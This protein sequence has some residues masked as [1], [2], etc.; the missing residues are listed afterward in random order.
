[1]SKLIAFAATYWIILLACY[2]KY[3]LKAAAL[4]F[5]CSI[6]TACLAGMMISVEELQE[7]DQDNDE[8]SSG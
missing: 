5:V 8:Q 6:V 7:D 1:M 2:C 3:G 4:C